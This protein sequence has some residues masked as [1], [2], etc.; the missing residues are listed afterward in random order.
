MRKGLLGAAVAL[1]LSSPAYAATWF[2]NVS[3]V[4]TGTTQNLP[5]ACTTGGIIGICQGPPSTPFSAFVERQIIVN[6]FSGT[7]Q[8]SAI[9]NINQNPFFGPLIS[10]GSLTYSGPTSFFA[11]NITYFATN[12][13]GNP[14]CQFV[15]C[16]RTTA[17]AATFQM[18]FV[19]SQNGPGPIP[20]PATWAM[21]FA[22]LGVVGAA[23]RHNR[24]KTTSLSYG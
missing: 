23:L 18:N 15:S 8:G 21:M 7:I 3:G 2:L 16:F 1:S 10:I 22:G 19:S 6:S 20:E 12:N 14:N 13:D 11:S 17:T 5:Y 24:K 4:V 9:L